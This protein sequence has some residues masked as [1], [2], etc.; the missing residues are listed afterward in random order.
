[1]S[2]SKAERFRIMAAECERQAQLAA[3]EEAE[4]RELQKRLAHSFHALAE[5]EDWLDGCAPSLPGEAR[6]TLEAA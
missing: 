5:N 4:F 1:M 3:A 6:D 2:K